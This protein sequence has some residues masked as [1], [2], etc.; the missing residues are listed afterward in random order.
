MP[1]MSR[2]S[3]VFGCDRTT[4]WPYAAPVIA[5]ESLAIRHVIGTAWAASASLTPVLELTRFKTI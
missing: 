1:Q 2:A 4:G 5:A 3:C